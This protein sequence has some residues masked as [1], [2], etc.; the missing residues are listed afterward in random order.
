MGLAILVILFT[1]VALL[2]YRYYANAGYIHGSRAKQDTT[3]TIQSQRLQNLQT[4]FPGQF[5]G[6]IAP[7][8]PNQ[9]LAGY[10]SDPKPARISESIQSKYSKPSISKRGHLDCDSVNLVYFG[11]LDHDL[12]DCNQPLARWGFGMVLFACDDLP[13]FSGCLFPAGNGELSESYLRCDCFIDIIRNR[14][15]AISSKP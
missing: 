9:I 8:S 2:V 5:E 14:T 15:G 6:T 10:P 13:G 1:V 3:L 11:Q 4:K 7:D 12:A